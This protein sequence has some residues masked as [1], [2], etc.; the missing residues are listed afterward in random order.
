MKT[1]PRVTRDELIGLLTKWERGGVTAQQAW[2]WVSDRYW[3]GD[4]EVDDWEGQL[5]ATNEVLA[6]L[7]SM[8]INWVV[9]DDVPIHRSFLFSPRE[10]TAQAFE[11]W[12]LELESID[13]RQRHRV[14]RDDPM[15]RPGFG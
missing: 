5:S 12:K 1:P 4:T 2:E 11:V 9:V 3:P 8:D 13:Y 14:L 6:L 15:Y 10:Q 7:D